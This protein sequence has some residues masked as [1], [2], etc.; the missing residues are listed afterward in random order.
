KLYASAGRV[1]YS[2]P[3]HPAAR[4]YTTNTFVTSYNYSS[5]SLVPDPLAPPPQLIQVGSYV[6][7][8][9]DPGLHRA[10]PD[11][12]TVGFEKAIDTTLSVGVKGS[13]RELGSVIED[14]CDLDP[15]T[16]PYGASCALANPGS[17]GPVARG[18]YATCDGSGNPT[19]PNS[20][21]YPPN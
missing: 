7:E 14:R 11:E 3:T 6:G 13:Y 1:Y 18:F 5:T 21:A 20:P 12:L 8:P 2:L 19:D 16:S 9:V 15:S 4:G 10:Y 17:S